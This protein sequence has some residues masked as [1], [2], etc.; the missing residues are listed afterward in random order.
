[1]DPLSFTSSLVAIL[2]ASGDVLRYLN[3][4]RSASKER[5]KCAIELAQLQSLLVMLR[6]RIEE[7]ASDQAWFDAVQQLTTKNGPLDQFKET[8][9][10]LKS[11][12]SSEGKFKK[13]KE[14]LLWNFKKE[15]FNSMLNSMER[16]K[17]L[18][19]V[20]LEMDHL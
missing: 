4:V 14:A 15:E 7:D 5:A 16:L 1:M 17:S 13:T 6:F 19:Q 12:L 8:L 18:V 2:S 9:E 3:D 20:A 10:T 11:Q